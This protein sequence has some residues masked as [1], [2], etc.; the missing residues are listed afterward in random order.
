LALT[1]AARLGRRDR[2]VEAHLAHVGRAASLL[3]TF[4]FALQRDA[5]EDPVAAHAARIALVDIGLEDRVD[6]LLRAIR[7]LLQGLDHAPCRGRDGRFARRWPPP[8]RAKR[9]L[10]ARR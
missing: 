2:L 4:S 1:R 3:M 8:P 7:D 5:V 9:F 6:R 10:P